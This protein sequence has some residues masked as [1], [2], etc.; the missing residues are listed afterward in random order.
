MY[1]SNARTH[2]CVC[3]YEGMY[4]CIFVCI[5]VCIFVCT[6]ICTYVCIFLC[7]YVCMYVFIYVGKHRVKT[8]NSCTIRPGAWQCLVAQAPMAY[9]SKR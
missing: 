8:F 5:Y 7:M 2:V 6:Y 3:M 4:V 9:M 1:V